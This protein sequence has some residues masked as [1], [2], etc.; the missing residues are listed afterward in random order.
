MADFEDDTRIA[1]EMGAWYQKIEQGHSPECEIP[2]GVSIMIETNDQEILDQSDQLSVRL[3]I[4]EPK[5]KVYFVTGDN[6]E[7]IDSCPFCGAQLFKLEY[8]RLKQK[9]NQ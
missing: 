6:K 8:E 2:D 1:D 3:G 4:I 9:F 7:E 5:V